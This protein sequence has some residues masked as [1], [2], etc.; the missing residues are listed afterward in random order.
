MGEVSLE[1][2]IELKVV[3]LLFGKGCVCVFV[4]VCVCVC[5]YVHA[6]VRVCLKGYKLFGVGGDMFLILTL[7]ICCQGRHYFCSKVF[8]FG[9]TNIF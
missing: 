9:C 2:P 8:P 3:G 4:C 7:L 1:Y 6:C 5:A